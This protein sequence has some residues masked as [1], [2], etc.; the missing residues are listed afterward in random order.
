MAGLVPAMTAGS[1]IRQDKFC[2]LVDAIGGHV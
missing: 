1:L 2:D